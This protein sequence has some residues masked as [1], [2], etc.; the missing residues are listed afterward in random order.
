MSAI[1]EQIE[2]LTYSTD[3][4]FPNLGKSFVDICCGST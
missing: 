3:E 1:E 2:R 4:K